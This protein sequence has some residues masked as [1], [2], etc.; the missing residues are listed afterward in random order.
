MCETLTK[1]CGICHIAKPTTEFYK[2]ANSKDG[3]R[4]YCKEC[5][6]RL[7]KEHRHK[8][9][10]TRDN[11]TIPDYKTCSK[12]LIY[13]STLDF[14]RGTD[15][16]DG[17][18]HWCKSCQSS[19]YKDWRNKNKLKNKS[20]TPEKQSLI[21]ICWNCKLNLAPS[22]FYTSNSS[23]DGLYDLCINCCYTRATLTR[24]IPKNKE[25]AKEYN[26]QYSQKIKET[27]LAILEAGEEIPH[28][29][30]KTCGT[31]L[32]TLPYTDFHKDIS[33]IDGLGR[34]C[35]RCS[36]ISRKKTNLK[37]TT[38]NKRNAKD[39]KRRKTRWLS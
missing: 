35:K 19:F 34:L 25:K 1:T 31:C 9:A 23:K 4:G 15:P 6:A 14:S 37:P 20:K 21:K 8:I 2:K 33:N 36:S 27:N 30:N 5:M 11:L 7:G 16:S 26:K 38:K 39:K 12:C 3:L 29:D 28:P 22:N 24:A 18:T 17:L 10:T 13:K 32:N